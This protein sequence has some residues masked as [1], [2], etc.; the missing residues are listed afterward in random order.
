MV[1]LLVILFLILALG[2]VGFAAWPLLR[3]AGHRGRYL[4]A[5]AL[6]LLVLELGLGT[7][8]MVGAPAL[9]LRSLTGPSPTDVRGLVATL[10]TRVLQNPPDPRGW[11]FRGR[12]YL[13]LND[14]SDAAAAFKQAILVAPSSMRGPLLS[15][16]G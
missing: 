5:G 15:A 7:Y 8:L 9:A 14:P 12:G 4:L 1:F 10:A 2:A 11:I 13:A 6:A 16:Y 3:D